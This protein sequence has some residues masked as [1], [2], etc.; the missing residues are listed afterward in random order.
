MTFINPKG[1]LAF[2]L[3]TLVGCTRAPQVGARL[4]ALDSKDRDGNYI[5]KSL[6]VDDVKSGVIYLKQSNEYANP[7][8]GALA[9]VGAGYALSAS[10]LKGSSLDDTGVRSGEMS[11]EKFRKFISENAYSL[12]NCR[13]LDA[14]RTEALKK[15][16]AENERQKVR[17]AQEAEEKRK[18]LDM[19][20]ARKKELLGKFQVDSVFC[21]IENYEEID[22]PFSIAF[23][24]VQESSVTQVPAG[25]AEISKVIPR[26]H[27]NGDLLSI[28]PPPGP[29]GP[30]MRASLKLKVIKG[31]LN[32]KSSDIVPTTGLSGPEVIETEAPSSSEGGVLFGREACIRKVKDHLAWIQTYIKEVKAYEGKTGCRQD[33]GV[34][35]PD[36]FKIGNIW[37]SAQEE[38]VRSFKYPE[39]T[40]D[41]VRADGTSF[42]W[43]ENAD[44]L[45][46][47][48]R[49]KIN[50][51]GK[52][53][54]QMLA[55]ETSST[56]F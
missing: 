52:E 55:K 8:L 4:C 25:F 43:F 22:F 12:E 1:A 34:S 28:P 42:R 32:S 9:E 36:L 31:Y 46:F 29:E 15:I 16:A 18:K 51:D 3:A 5:G 21:V 17:R 11:L 13:R 49:G 47:L 26:R 48:K 23:Y 38:P 44:L 19:D 33:S 37:L 35:D 24:K 56:K 40:V 27:L 41:R 2:C 39:V 54:L 7:V 53:C 10:G 30:K 20:M 14:K 50:W 6:V 45:L